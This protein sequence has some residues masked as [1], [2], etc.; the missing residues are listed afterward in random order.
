M[1]SLQAMCITTAKILIYRNVCIFKGHLTLKISVFI[2]PY[3]VVVKWAELRPIQN[4]VGIKKP[5]F[6]P[7]DLSPYHL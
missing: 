7:S 3:L 5:V 1:L 6:W 2:F 4:R